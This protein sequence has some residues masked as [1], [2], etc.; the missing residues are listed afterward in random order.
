VVH[1]SSFCAGGQQSRRCARAASPDPGDADAAPDED[2]RRVCRWNAYF[3]QP[4]A[5]ASSSTRRSTGLW[6]EVPES[7]ALI[8]QPGADEQ[9]PFSPQALAAV[10]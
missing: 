3:G 8:V 4:L 5:T 9:V 2:D 1:R 10:G 6:I 7:T